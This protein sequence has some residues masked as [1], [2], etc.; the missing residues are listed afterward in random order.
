M[1]YSNSSEQGINGA[2]NLPRFDEAWSVLFVSFHLEVAQS[3]CTI[4]KLFIISTLGISRNT[5]YF[6]A[7]ISVMFLCTECVV[8]V[9]FA[10]LR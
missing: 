4:I 8:S 2:S 7:P 10:R 9:C 1:D 5:D 3:C 6:H